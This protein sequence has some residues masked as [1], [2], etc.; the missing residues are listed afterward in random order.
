MDC[1]ERLARSACPRF[2]TS[3]AW[4]QAVAEGQGCGAASIAVCLLAIRPAG[5]L[6]WSEAA[7]IATPAAHFGRDGLLALLAEDA[8][9]NCCALP[10][11]A[12]KVWGSDAFSAAA[13]RLLH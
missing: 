13:S 10:T 4:R 12:Q 3:A 8:E 7:A 9:W 2:S 1:G 6:P 5:W 11:S